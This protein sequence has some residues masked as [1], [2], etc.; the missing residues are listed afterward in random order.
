[1]IAIYFAVPYI[2]ICCIFIFI[3]LKI[4]NNQLLPLNSNSSVTNFSIVIAAKNEEENLLGLISAL[5]K[6][7]YPKENFEVI[8]VDDNSDDKT[9]Q[10]ATDLTST[11]ENFKVVKA[12]DKR[13]EGK[14]GALDY[15]IS[16]AKHENIIITDA[17]CIPESRWLIRYEEKFGK[18]FDLIIGIAPFI[19]KQ[20]LVN[21]ISCYENFRNTL[22]TILSVKIGLPY[23][24][25]A[26]N[27]GFKKK[28]FE[29]FE[30]YKNTTDTISGDDDL[31]LR[32]A[33]KNNLTIGLL[34]SKDSFVFSESKKSFKDYFNQ[35]AR[36]TQTSFHYSLKQILFLLTWHIL[37]IAFLFSPLLAFINLYFLLPF[38]IK[39]ILD[40]LISVLS[41]R[42]ISYNFSFIETVY[43]QFFYE[44][45]LI[46]HLFNAKF[47][48]IK[49]K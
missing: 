48:R 30:G 35:R 39:L 31:L 19:Q 16:I 23:T 15:G 49:W 42:K 12:E 45:F 14:R 8:I 27:F 29:E 2:I 11:L 4:L 38:A 28:S 41:Q 7:D 5:S 24:A 25:S 37:N 44:I 32:E 33:V 6:I 47:G 22:L 13:Y 43:L 26:R 10:L 1:M 9:F 18:G 40:L 17:D 46:V 3:L 20:T 36:H 21:K 34:T